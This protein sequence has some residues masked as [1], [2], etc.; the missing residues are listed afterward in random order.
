[1]NA[2]SMRMDSRLNA[3]EKLRCRVHDQL[4]SIATSDRLSVL[5]PASGYLSYI[6]DL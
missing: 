4:K 5:L 1:M 6:A 2:H 3:G